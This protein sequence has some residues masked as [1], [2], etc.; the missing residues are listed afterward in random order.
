MRIVYG[1]LIA[2]LGVVVVAGLWWLFGPQVSTVAK[3]DPVPQALTAS[4]SPI[5]FA[6]IIDTPGHAATGTVT[7]GT[8]EQGQTIV[9]LNDFST[10]NG[11]DLFVYLA[12]DIKATEF[13]SLGELQ[14]TNGNQNYVVPDAKLLATHPYVLVWCKRFGVLFNYADISSLLSMTT[15]T[16]DQNNQT[17]DVPVVTTNTPTSATAIFANGC[18]WCVEHD[19]EKVPGVTGVVSGYAGGTTKNPTYETYQDGN[20]REVVEVTYNPQIVSYANLVEHIIKHGDPT[21]AEGSFYDRG[22][23]YSPAI[24]F[25][26][27]EEESTA[28]KVITVINDAKRFSAPLTIPVVPRT[29]F[30][31]AEEYHQ[32]YAKK[33]P[34]RYGYYRA[35]SGRTKFYEK[36][37]GSEASTFTFS[38][39]PTGVNNQ[40]SNMVPNSEQKQFTAASWVSFVKP[41][42][43]QLKSSLSDIAYRVT[44]DDATERAGTSPLDQEYGRGIYVDVVSGEPLFLSRDK[45]DS[46]TGWPSFVKP[47]NDEVVTLHEDKKLFSTRTEVRSRYADSH[48]GHVFTD[49]PADRGGMRYCMNGAALRFVSESAMSAAGYDYLLAAL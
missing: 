2:L 35:A 39:V 12:T 33:N 37:W 10:I 4:T 1:S 30:F 36:V 40:S 22:V 25:A 3:N 9:R 43:D 8:N 41:S 34:I 28:Q 31:A 20:H 16:T 18:F 19:L 27:P 26:T 44:Q 5:L 47:I 23:A 6:P 17:T 29:E 42:A 46:G 15:T 24:Y 13:L 32:D 14:S 7:L 11:P 45:Y 48:L 38:V 49:G 21:D